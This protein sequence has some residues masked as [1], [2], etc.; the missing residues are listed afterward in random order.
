MVRL[1]WL[2]SRDIGTLESYSQSDSFP[3]T[4]AGNIQGENKGVQRIF[5]LIPGAVDTKPI[6]WPKEASLEKLPWLGLHVPGQA[7]RHFKSC[8]QMYSLWTSSD[9]I[10]WDLVRKVQSWE[11]PLWLSG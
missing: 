6:I 2:W 7:P 8:Y 1:R 11:F 3:C 10:T 5:V 4:T 9:G